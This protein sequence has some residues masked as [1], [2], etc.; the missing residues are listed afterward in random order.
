MVTGGCVSADAW[1]SLLAS[2]PPEKTPAIARIT[3][4][5]ITP[6]AAKPAIIRDWPAERGVEGAALSARP[7]AL[8]AGAV[9]AA[10][11]RLT[12]G[13]A[14]RLAPPALGLGDPGKLR[15]RGDRP[16]LDADRLG[17]LA[18]LGVGLQ[19]ADRIG[20]ADRV[21]LAEQEVGEPDLAVGIV[22]AELAQSA[23]APCP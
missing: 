22:A 19:V 9:S 18:R 2:S 23:R 16:E 6:P 8:R 1:A 17:E 15:G 11:Q 10:R 12:G 4:S 7:G 20:A 5:R 21:G 13:R 14:G 3:K